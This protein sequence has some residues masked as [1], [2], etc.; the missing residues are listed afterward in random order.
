MQNFV[1]TQVHD[2]ILGLIDRAA[3]IV[4][5]VSPFVRP[6]PELRRALARAVCR[7][8]SISLITRGPNGGPSTED[9]DVFEQLEADVKEVPV[10]HL[11]AYLSE[12]EALHTSV[13]LTRQSVG[14]SVE[15]S[16]L[17]DREQDAEGWAQVYEIWR[18]GPGRPR[19]RERRG[20][21]R[22]RPG[23]GWFEG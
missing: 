2:E 7:G 12:K 18:K 10:R 4:V 13:N 3:R 14:K 1:G 22:L 17:F 9:L 5:L 20:A 21:R 6:W 19:A 8:V 16:L 23:R 11:K 15:S